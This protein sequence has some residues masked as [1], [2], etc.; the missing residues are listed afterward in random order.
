ML[1]L[2]AGVLSC[3][4]PEDPPP[5]ASGSPATRSPDRPAAALVGRW[6]Q[7]HTCQH[8]VDALRA[9]GLDAL[10]PSV[11]GDYFPEFSFDELAAKKDV[12]SGA[13]PQPHYHFFDAEGAFGSL[14]QYENQVDDGAY[15]IVD[16]DTVRIGDATF[17]YRVRGD[18]L[19]LTPVITGKQ[20]RQALRNPTDFSTAGWMVAVTYPGTTWKRVPCEAW[21]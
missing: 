3:S 1:A 8:L 7:L 4:A 9:R 2:V 12:C 18:T 16:S 13:R 14:D 11:V 15:S 21:C 6:E 19:R 17:D 20:R 5:G 10:A